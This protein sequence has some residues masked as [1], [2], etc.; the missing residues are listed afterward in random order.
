MYRSRIV[1]RPIP[2]VRKVVMI[3]TNRHLPINLLDAICEPAIQHDDH[4]RHTIQHGD[5]VEIEE[6][7]P[8]TYLKSKKTE[9][10][11]IVPLLTDDVLKSLK[12][13]AP[14]SQSPKV[15]RETEVFQSLPRVDCKAAVMDPLSRPIEF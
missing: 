6:V 5:D 7:S 15:Q 4:G 2:I 14:P 3:S 13:E 1:I 10:A 9:P 12:E 11:S 8:E